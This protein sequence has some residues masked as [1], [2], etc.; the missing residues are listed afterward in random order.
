MVEGQVDIADWFDSFSYQRE[1]SFLHS[2][3]NETMNDI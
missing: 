2:F 1:G 3:P